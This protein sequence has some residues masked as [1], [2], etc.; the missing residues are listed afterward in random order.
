MEIKKEK[1][2]NKNFD[3]PYNITK[4]YLDQMFNTKSEKLDEKL[5]YHIDNFKITKNLIG[6]FHD[7]ITIKGNYL[8]SLVFL[9]NYY[10]ENQTPTEIKKEIISYAVGCEISVSKIF[11]EF[12]EYEVEKYKR[13]T[14]YS[15]LISEILLDKLEN[16]SMLALSFWKKLDENDIEFKNLL[17]KDKSVNIKNVKTYLNDI[18]FIINDIWENEK[19]SIKDIFQEWISVINIKLYDYDILLN[20]YEEDKVSILKY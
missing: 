6:K 5:K 9:T 16:N 17:E 10:I 12:S 7:E 15:K 14:E 8:N 11:S 19:R 18:T 13:S 1:I 3:I 20:P 4:N 2:F